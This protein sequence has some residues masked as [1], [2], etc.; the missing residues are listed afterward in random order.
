MMTKGGAGGGAEKYGFEVA[1]PLVLKTEEGAE[2]CRWPLE[3]W[4]GKDTDYSLE[5]QKEHSLADPF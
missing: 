4:K 2:E 5:P 3:A 1:M